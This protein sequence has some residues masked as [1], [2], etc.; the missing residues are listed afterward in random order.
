MNVTAL[1]MFA[2]FAVLA[3]MWLPITAAARGLSSGDPTCRRSGRAL[4]RFGRT[5]ARRSAWRFEVTGAPPS[6]LAHS[7]CV[8]ISNHASLADPFLLSYLPF[9]LRFVA[10]D[11]LFHKP[12]VGW[13]LRLA[14]DIP[15]RRGDPAS[16]A[17]MASAAEAT[18][19]AGLSVMIFPEGTRSRS[20][21]LGAFRDGA[22]R[23]AIATG[24]PI[25][26]VALHGTAGCIGPGGPR[27]AHARAH[28]LPPIPTRGLVLADLPAL[29]EAARARIASELAGPPTLPAVDLGALARDLPAPRPSP[30]ISD[31]G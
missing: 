12:L 26:P 28:I 9:D 2:R 27:R 19:R 17:A 6:D 7:P 15:V 5:I 30:A 14:G 16:A 10:K 13:L 1:S 4:R 29:R 25:L 31:A 3:P 23:I 11:E 24:A 22:F 20:G 21:E 18:L 8:V